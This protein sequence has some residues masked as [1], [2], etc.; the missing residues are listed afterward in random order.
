[1]GDPPGE[2]ERLYFLY[3]NSGLVRNLFG[4]EKT[5]RYFNSVPLE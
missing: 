5:I 2:G 3:L 1:M 4:I